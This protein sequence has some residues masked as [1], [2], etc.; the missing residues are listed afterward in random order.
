MTTVFLIGM[1]L[2]FV[3]SDSP[4]PKQGTGLRVVNTPSSEEK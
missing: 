2:G 1:I 3:F 4:T